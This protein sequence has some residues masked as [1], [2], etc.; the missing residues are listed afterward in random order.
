MKQQRVDSKQNI[1]L[2]AQPIQRIP[3]TGGAAVEW[4]TWQVA[5]HLARSEKYVPHIIC[6]GEDDPSPEH[7]IREGVH[8]YRINLSRTYKRLFQKWTRLDPYGYAAR[9]ARYC[10]EID[11]KIVHT[12]NSPEL[13]RQMV[14]RLSGRKTILHMHNEKQPK[15]NFHADLLLTVSNYLA[16]WYEERLPDAKIQI[17]TNGIDK[18]IY[19]QTTTPPEWKKRL[20]ASKKVILYAGRISREKGVHLLAEAFALL[21]PRHPELQLVVI[22]ERSFGTHDRA[23]YADRLEEFLKPFS[24]QVDLIGSVHPE[25]MYRHYQ[26]GDLLVVPSISETFGMVCLEGMAAGI[27]VLAAPNG[28]LPEFVQ[29]GNTGF[30]I[31]EYG[32]APSLAA[33]IENIL[34]MPD[35]MRDI[36]AAGQIYARENHDWSFVSANLSEIYDQLLRNDV[37]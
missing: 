32:N 18:D 29:P 7:E 20:S 19:H 11:A 5:R 24:N 3:P 28:G 10:R 8:F 9:A 34:E 35:K 37:A 31:G 17:I 1:A 30:L 14:Q 15:G 2:V 16:Q 21:V 36:A 27:P 22:G 23:K 12:Q 33:Q 6:T 4:W 13:H 25:E 26:A